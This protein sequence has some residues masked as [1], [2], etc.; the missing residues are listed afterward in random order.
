M[1]A[2]ISYE[3]YFSLVLF[4]LFVTYVIFYVTSTVPSYTR[5]IKSQL[6][7][8]EAYQISEMLVNDPG[9]PADWNLAGVKRIGLS[10][11]TKNRTNLISF[12]KVSM[13]NTSC[14]TDYSSVAA[15]LGIDPKHQF[16]VTIINLTSGEVLVDCSP[17]APVSRGAVAE[18]T[19][20]A[21]VD[22]GSYVGVTVRMW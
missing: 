11:Q 15:G 1:K 3:Y 4:V 18:I 17:A 22:S 16:A 10:D 14:N 9:E 2:Q 20:I 6:L 7:V 8:S 13:L 21:A 5:E 19:R 12:D